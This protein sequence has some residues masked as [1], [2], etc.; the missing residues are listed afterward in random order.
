MLRETETARDEAEE[1]ARRF[2]ALL[3]LAPN[4]PLSPQGAA[5]AASP[6]APTHAIY[7]AAPSIEQAA[8]LES[9]GGLEAAVQEASSLAAMLHRVGERDGGRVRAGSPPN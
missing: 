9:I 4:S 3:V 7:D 5:A 1:A 8:A 6:V 2:Q